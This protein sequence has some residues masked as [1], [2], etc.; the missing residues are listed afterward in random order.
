MYALVGAAFAA[1]VQYL[2]GKAGMPTSW[3]T[4]FV[5]EDEYNRSLPTVTLA[6]VARNTNDTLG[7]YL[8]L[9]ER[10]DYPKALID[11]YVRTDAS[12]DGTAQTL[13]RWK[14]RVGHRYHSVVFSP[15]A[16]ATFDAE[17][18][19][20]N[21]VGK[22]HCWNARRFAAIMDARQDTLDYAKKLGTDY[23]FSVDTDV[24]LTSK[25]TLRSLIDAG[26][27]IAAPLLRVSGAP[28]LTNFW[29]EVT[30]NG[31]YK[32]GSEDNKILAHAQRGAHT[33]KVVHSTLLID[34]RPAIVRD[35]LSY[36]DMPKALEWM[37]KDD[38][39]VFGAMARH[40]NID[41]VVL[42]DKF[43]GLMLNTLAEEQ[44]MEGRRSELRAIQK[45]YLTDPCDAAE[46][47]VLNEMLPRKDLF[48]DTT[49]QKFKPAYTTKDPWDESKH[50]L[51][52]STL[53][54]MCE[55][56]T[57]FRDRAYTV[58]FLDGGSD[59]EVV[60][61]HEAP[62]INLLRHVVSDADIEELIALAEPRLKTAV[63]FDSVSGQMVPAPYRT[64]QSAWLAREKHPVVAKIY[65]RLK[66]LT[67]LD[68]QVSEDL[69]IARYNEDGGRYAPHFD[70]GMYKYRDSWDEYH[71]NRIA[72]VLI[73]LSANFT[74][75][76]TAFT[77]AGACVQAEKG[78]GVFWYNLLPT[79]IGDVR[80]KHGGCPVQGDE[81]GSFTKWVANAWFVEGANRHLYNTWGSPLRPPDKSQHG[82]PKIVDD[83]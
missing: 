50:E 79:G 52:F 5:E 72:T 18:D 78:S 68:A 56:E 46:A 35:H 44:T 81:T 33:A 15:R 75:G 42:N 12:F 3:T 74:G 10:Q 21:C 9:I 26:S 34:L 61:L 49:V 53:C 58:P 20:G 31:Y 70:F 69:Q 38:I 30:K 71:G 17:T 13:Q 60:P 65:E 83:F 59:V 51:L 39:V 22:P 45:L 77:R 80:T 67:G 25:T 32:R 40:Y 82:S 55:T 63:V 27:P 29:S 48:D 16:R 2:L 57:K 73:Y 23:Y 54:M 6:I 1:L 14:E 7:L 62:Q 24:F 11:V 19:L 4:S 43:Y 36:L 37:Y 8:P 64:A 41:Q 66:V 28:R 47:F 76:G